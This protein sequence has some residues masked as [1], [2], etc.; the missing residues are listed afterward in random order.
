MLK[1]NFRAR[2]FPANIPLSTSVILLVFCATFSFGVQAQTPTP[3][4]HIES[5]LMGCE[6]GTTRHRRAKFYTGPELKSQDSLFRAHFKY[7]LDGPSGAGAP[8][9]ITPSKVSIPWKGIREAEDLVKDNVGQPVRG[10]FFHYG[11]DGVKFH[12]VIQFMYPD[13]TQRGDLKLYKEKYFHL[14]L[15]TGGLKEIKYDSCK[16]YMEAYVDKVY[17]TRTEGAGPTKI[18][19]DSDP[20]AEWFSY[21]DNVNA[22]LRD[23]SPG[24]AKDLRLVVNCI[25]E[26]LCYAEM[27]GAAPPSPEFRHLLALNM[28]DGDT[29]FLRS[30]PATISS[31]YQ[32]MA[33]DLGHLCPPLCK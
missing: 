23:N 28:A 1:M 8:Q 9:E 17:V 4:V 30:T 20:V 13:D 31:I 32:E 10:I 7:D 18:Q 12:P 25:S 22:L 2:P 15:A 21:P 29:D 19:P 27:I 3:G 24:T 16:K 11:M 26:Q 6:G 5:A 33:M 14:D